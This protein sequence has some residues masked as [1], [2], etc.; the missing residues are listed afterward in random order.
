[1]ENINEALMAL[2]KLGHDD[3]A[4]LEVLMEC[5]GMKKHLELYLDWYKNKANDE[6]D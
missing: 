3:A 6:E 5:P 1:M 2:R 4:I